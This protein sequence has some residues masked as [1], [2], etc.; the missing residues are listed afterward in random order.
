[1]TPLFLFSMLVIYLCSH[2]TADPAPDWCNAVLLPFDETP[3]PQPIWW[4]EYYTYATTPNI[5]SL[6]VKV[7]PGV[8]SNIPLLLYG[9]VNTCPQPQNGF[10]DTIT[11]AMNTVLVK[12]D[13]PIFPDA[14][15]TTYL[16]V[17]MIGGNYS[18]VTCLPDS[19]CPEL[20]PD[21]CLYRG[22]C[23]TESG[24]C[25]CQLGWTG[26]SCNETA[27]LCNGTDCE[28]PHTKQHS[29]KFYLLVAGLPVLT[30][31]I[32][33]TVGAYILISRHKDEQILLRTS[34]YTKINGTD[35]SLS[36]VHPRY[37][38]QNIEQS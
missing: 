29:L 3:V 23:E 37:G 13:V 35:S 14:V 28:P 5:T 8:F 30:V 6:T 19:F 4:Q 2:A 25:I 7:Y 18:I 34:G 10:F 16:Y 31:F 21:D 15:N 17:R 11:Y 26:A 20:C 27:P 33:G 32:L 22:Y 38:Y 12:Y 24:S 9:R 1:M 36:S